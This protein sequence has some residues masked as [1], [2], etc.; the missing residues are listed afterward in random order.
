MVWSLYVYFYKINWNDKEMTDVSV[1]IKRNNKY[2]Q[3]S[4]IISQKIYSH[5][6]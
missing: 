5:L 2:K 1:N 6:F 4:I 3:I